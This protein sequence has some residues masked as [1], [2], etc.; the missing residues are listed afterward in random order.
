M[1]NW[2]SVVFQRLRKGSCR[3]YE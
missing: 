1:V 3:A 2:L